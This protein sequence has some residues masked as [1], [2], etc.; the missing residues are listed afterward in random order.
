MCAPFKCYL[1]P[2]NGFIALMLFCSVIQSNL[3]SL[4][5][6]IV[7]FFCFK[8]YHSSCIVAFDL[9]ILNVYMVLK[10]SSSHWIGYTFTN[11]RQ[12][13]FYALTWV[14]FHEQ[15]RRKAIIKGVWI[16]RLIICLISIITNMFSSLSE[17]S[18][19]IHP[20]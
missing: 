1:A 13:R 5:A 12:C 16:T 6:R 4:L 17:N 9:I 8:Q 2:V 7:L 10:M 15:I 20:F 3:N 19:S 18:G 11:A 14:P